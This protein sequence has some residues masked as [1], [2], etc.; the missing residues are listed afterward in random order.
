MFRAPALVN[1]FRGV[2]AH[3]LRLAPA[4]RPLSSS[5]VRF[6]EE[7][8]A[9][10]DTHDVEDLFNSGNEQGGR[11]Q[12]EGQNRRRRATNLNNV[13]LLGGV[14]NDPVERV[15]RTGNAY[16]T[17]DMFT[18]VEYRRTDGSTDE[19][20]ELHN[21]FV[22]GGNANYVLKNVQKGTRV[23][24]SGRLHYTGG[25]LGV[26]GQRIP[27][28]ACIVADIVQPIAKAQGSFEER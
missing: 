13:Q 21:I 24:L 10:R 26:A 7:T 5:T 8:A 14:A 17:F 2:V 6:V 25:N 12:P 20:V 3:G 9:K 22:F 23:F 4:V 11:K 18:N 15:G 19:R 27:R 28:S 1:R 16:C